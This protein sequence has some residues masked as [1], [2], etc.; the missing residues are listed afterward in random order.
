M[1]IPQE[2]QILLDNHND[3]ITNKQV[4]EIGVSRDPTGNKKCLKIVKQW[5]VAEGA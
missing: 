3:T 4:S 5:G 1:P 2:I